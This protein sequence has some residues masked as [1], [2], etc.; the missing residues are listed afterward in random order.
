MPPKP[1]TMSYEDL[2]LSPLN[3]RQQEAVQT[4]DGPVLILA[5][6]GSGKTR[7]LTYRIAYLMR[8]KNVSAEHILALTFTNKAAREMSER[9]LKLI[10]KNHGP[11]MGTFHSFCARLLRAH[12]HNI[13]ISPSFTIYDSDQ[14]R[15][16]MKSVIID[17]KF[18]PKDIAPAA[19]LQTVGTWKDSLMT[20]TEASHAA[21]SPWEKRVATLWDAYEKR[22]SDMQAVDFDGLLTNAVRLLQQHESVRQRI[23]DQ[24]RYISVDEYQDTNNCQFVLLKLLAGTTQNICVVG[25]D[26][27]AIYGWRGA[28]VENIRQFPNQFSGCKTVTLDQNYRSTERILTAAN[29][30]ISQSEEML[31]KELWTNNEKGSH[32]H[33]IRAED[34]K[35]EGKRILR[36]FLRLF[37][38]KDMSPSDTA[39]L[40]RT[41]AQSRALEEACLSYGMPYE[42]IGGMT[43]YERKEVKDM[44]SYFSWIQNPNDELSFRR[45][46]NVPTRGIGERTVEQ[47][48]STARELKTDPL[49]RAVRERILPPAKQEIVKNLADILAPIREAAADSRPTTLL[50][51][52]IER[53]KFREWLREESIRTTGTPEQG[54][55]RYENVLELSTVADRHD[56]L[57]AFLEEVSLISDAEKTASSNATTNERIK[58]MTI[59]AAK[60]LEFSIVAVAGVEEGLLPHQ[61]SFESATAIEEERRLC[62]VAMTRAMRELFLSYARSRHV[63]GKLMETTKSRFLDDIQ[64]MRLAEQA[65]EEHIGKRDVGTFLDEPSIQLDEL[66]S[67]YHVGDVVR[68]AMFGTGTIT[69]IDGSRLTV[70]FSCGEKLLDATI[71]PLQCEN[72]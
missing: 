48:L 16:L 46:A 5:G 70:A 38:Q 57:T 69:H 59:H 49:D 7:T 11:T 39:I 18:S 65:P 68:H 41:N 56:S 3:D 45:L 72:T 14:T 22:L 55:R 6:A 15:S 19:V 1:Q 4:T 50:D 51:I 31:K 2:L 62:Y 26:A 13:G 43:F 28:R 21:G 71:A 36:A 8:I 66:D 40:Y 9:L 53:L 17:H 10:S 63:Y 61:N 33:L 34:E 24:Y 52:L 37:E 25:D 27:Q 12:G 42:I 32:I 23:E 35:D 60:G 54:E 47:L 29:C 64:D 44:L 30:V 58:L 20:P 67:K